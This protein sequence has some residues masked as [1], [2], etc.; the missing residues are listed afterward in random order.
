[1]QQCSKCLESV[2]EFVLHRDGRAKDQLARPFICE[3]CFRDATRKRHAEDKRRYRAEKPEEVRA[4]Y[5]EWQLQKT[6]G[7]SLEQFTSMLES[8]GG[9][10]AI[11][12]ADEPGWDK[13]WHVD[14]CHTTHKNRGI[15][16]HRCNLMIGLAKEQQE[17]FLAAIRYLKDL[18]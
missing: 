13:D 12:K 1:M 4:K 7:L 18:V 17:V 2:S 9:R 5:R 8:Q 15:L 14:H 6:Y 10:C 11:C 3:R 16:C